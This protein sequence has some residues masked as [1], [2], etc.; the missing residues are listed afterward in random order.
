MIDYT[1]RECPFCGNPAEIIEGEPYSWCPYNRVEIIRCSNEYCIG[2]SIDR[3]FMPD[4]KSSELMARDDWN[5]RRRKNKLTWK[6]AQ[7]DD[8]I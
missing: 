8:K 1:L 3:R 5:T 7:E 6:E 4:L 2:H